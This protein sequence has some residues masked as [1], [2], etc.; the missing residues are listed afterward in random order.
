MEEILNILKRAREN[1]SEL[2]AQ[3]EHIERIR[4]II[5]TEQRNGNNSKLEKLAKLERRLNTQIEASIEAK[6]A[7]LDL[8]NFLTGEERGVIE[9]YYILAKSWDDIAHEMYI[10][11]RK[12]YL[13]RNKALARI[14][15]AIK[16]EAS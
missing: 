1:E 16:K 11:D 12:V 4:R 8:V 5:R 6:E 10:C 2:C 3:L 15:E 9:S 7:A 14:A 13:I